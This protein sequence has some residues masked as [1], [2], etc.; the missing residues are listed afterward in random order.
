MVDPS[1]PRPTWD[2]CTIICCRFHNF[3][4][5]YMYPET[6]GFCFFYHC[7][8]F[9]CEQ[10]IEY[11]MARWSIRRMWKYRT[12][13]IL[14][15]YILS[16]VCLRLGQFSQLSFAKYMRLCVFRSLI[17]LMMILIIRVLYRIIIMI[18]LFYPLHV[19]AHPPEII[20]YKIIYNFI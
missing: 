15:R 16:H 5:M 9:R 14:D 11:I 4:Y 7:A 12:S 20:I 6:V 19:T 1:G 18:N 10:I 2:G 8:V 3:I 17:Y 13:I